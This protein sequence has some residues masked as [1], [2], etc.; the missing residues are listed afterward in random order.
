MYQLLTGKHPFSRGGKV[1]PERTE[2]T[3]K[4][5]VSQ[6][7]HLKMFCSDQAKDLLYKLCNPNSLGRYSAKEAL[8]HPWVTGDL[9]TPA[10]LTYLEEVTH[11]RLRTALRV[12][13]FAG[14]CAVPLVAKTVPASR[15]D[16]A[17]QSEEKVR[18]RPTPP[19]QASRSFLIRGDRTSKYPSPVKLMRRLTVH[20]TGPQNEVPASPYNMQ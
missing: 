11:F 13:F 15:K 12:T 6:N 7:W 14:L 3:L 4:A 17:P 20:N 1:G 18:I 10:P 19:L 8:R 2:E 9:T 5:M 16:S